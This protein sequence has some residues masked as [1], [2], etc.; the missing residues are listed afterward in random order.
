MVEGRTAL[1]SHSRKKA[2]DAGPLR[3]TPKASGCTERKPP[4]CRKCLDA[5]MGGSSWASSQ[6]RALACLASDAAKAWTAPVCSMFLSSW[7]LLLPETLR[8]SQGWSGYRGAALQRFLATPTETRSLRARRASPRSVRASR[9]PLPVGSAV[10]RPKPSRGAVIWEARR[11]ETVSRLARSF[12]AIQGQ[13]KSR[14]RAHFSAG[15]RMAGRARSASGK[16][17]SGRVAAARGA[18]AA[19]SVPAS[20][21]SMAYRRPRSGPDAVERH[22]LFSGPART[23]SRS[24]ADSALAEVRASALPACLRRTSSGASKRRRPGSGPSPSRQ[25]RLEK[26]VL[27]AAC[28]CRTRPTVR[29]PGRIMAASRGL[30]RY[31]RRPTGWTTVATVDASRY[32]TARASRRSMRMRSH[33][34]ETGRERSRSSGAEPSASASSRNPFAVRR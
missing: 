14:S 34:A 26:P 21:R 1:R 2:H 9:R 22:T 33:W 20:K 28:P 4:R 19:G 31:S 30:A 25:S 11:S 7:R 18:S 32:M 24:S 29:P 15:L 17:S 10:T 13:S 5:L 27:S 23:A 8:Q 6:P 3:R 12:G 16:E